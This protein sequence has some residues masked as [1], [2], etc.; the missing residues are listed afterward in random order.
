MGSS[1]RPSSTSS[2]VEDDATEAP[3]CLAL[4]SENSQHAEQIEVAGLP[5]LPASGAGIEK[6]D[7]LL[8]EGRQVPAERFL[9]GDDLLRA[10]LERDEQP[11]L[12][13]RSRAV[14][15]RLEECDTVLPAT[16]PRP[17][18]G[19]LRSIGRPPCV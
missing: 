17:M 7:F 4:A 13:R 10:L 18:M 19:V 5:I 6:K 1:S 14:D 2:S 3:I 11:R 9:L 16:R 12:V 8:L 15:Q